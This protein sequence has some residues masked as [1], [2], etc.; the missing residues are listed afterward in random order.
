MIWVGSGRTVGG[1]DFRIFRSAGEAVWNGLSPYPSLHSR[2]LHENRAFVYPLPAAWLFVPFAL[3]PM[4][5]AGPLF[6]AISV[7]AVAGGMLLLGVRDPWLFVI[8]ASSSLVISGLELGTVNALLFLLVCVIACRRSPAALCG[9]AYA[10]VVALKLFLC[11]L[12]VFMSLEVRRRSLTVAAGILALLLALSLLA[13]FSPWSY[14]RLLGR[15][16]AIEAT[17]SLSLLSALHQLGVGGTFGRAIVPGIAGAILA[18]AVVA[19][20]RGLERV[21]TF[22]ACLIAA[23]A[24]SP[25]VWSHYLLLAFI[26]AL[27]SGRPRLLSALIWAGGWLIYP[28]RMLGFT[29]G[30]LVHELIPGGHRALGVQLLLSGLLALVVAVSSP[31]ER[32]APR[33]R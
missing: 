12:V 19:H 27:L 9:A 18:G 28:V 24:L 22:S 6:L 26:P 2:L 23:F 15:L 31:G 21:V 20:R 30:P 7:A 29:P 1:F 32:D 14:T 8:I 16:S 3:L 17:R 10:V 4:H 11:P 33:A 5:L 25:I 13:D